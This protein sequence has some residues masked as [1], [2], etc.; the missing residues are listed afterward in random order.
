MEPSHVMPSLHM[1]NSY[2]VRIHQ[3]VY[4]LKVV[5][6]FNWLGS[7][8]TINERTEWSMIALSRVREGF[9][10]VT[11]INLLFSRPW[12]RSEGKRSLALDR[13]LIL[14][15]VIQ[16]F[17]NVERTWYQ[18]VVAWHWRYTSSWM[19]EG[20]WRKEEAEGE[21]VL[22]YSLSY[23]LDEWLGFVML[24]MWTTCGGSPGFQESR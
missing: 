9:L 4:I 7:P 19:E 11:K 2:E 8:A 13:S 12:T 21:R 18:K 24:Q 5:S 3:I 14:I 6:S 1:Y 17:A 23:H 10:E 20:R 15:S 16:H 22:D